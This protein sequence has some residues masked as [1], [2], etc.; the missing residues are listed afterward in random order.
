VR[1]DNTFL[2]GIVSTGDD[3]FYDFSDAKIRCESMI[4]CG[5]VTCTEENN[6]LCQVHKNSHL[7]SS[8]TNQISY[9]KKCG[10]KLKTENSWHYG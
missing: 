2:D 9:L 1:Y 3:K 6:N 8:T 10:G 4:D 7:E 5:G